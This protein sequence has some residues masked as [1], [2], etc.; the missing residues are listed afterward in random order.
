MMGAS[1]NMFSLRIASLWCFALVLRFGASLCSPVWTLVRHTHVT[2]F[3]TSFCTRR[4]LRLL[5]RFAH[6]CLSFITSFCTRMLL[7]LLLHF[8]HAC[9]FVYYFV[10]HTHVTSLLL[11]FAHACRFVYYFVLHT[12]VARDYTDLSTAYRT[13]VVFKVFDY[14]VFCLLN[15]GRKSREW[16]SL[17]T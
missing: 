6:A 16:L 7:R 15:K 11:H 14:F 9:Y 12:Q 17:C 13:L 10:L 3:I 8:A 4:L 5:L 2:S 1:L